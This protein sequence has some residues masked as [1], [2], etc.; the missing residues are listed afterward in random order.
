MGNFYA[1]SDRRARRARG[2]LELDGL[3]AELA[4]ALRL[5][6]VPVLDHELGR[7]SVGAELDCL[8]VRVAD[9]A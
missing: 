6:A 1:S 9:N 8:V 2:R 7:A 3:D 4:W 5:V